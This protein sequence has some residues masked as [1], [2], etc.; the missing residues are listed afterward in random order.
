MPFLQAMVATVERHSRPLG[1]LILNDQNHDSRRP[2]TKSMSLL[3][4]K[5]YLHI[6][7]PSQPAHRKYVKKIGNPGDEKYSYNGSS[8]NVIFDCKNNF[9]KS[10]QHSTNMP[11]Q[12]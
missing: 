3:A 6:C 11:H 2:G 10:F 8:I 12:R 9:Q 5:K 7:R 4:D 1:L